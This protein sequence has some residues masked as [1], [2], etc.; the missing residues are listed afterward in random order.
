[1]VK[2]AVW[3]VSTGHTGPAAEAEPIA[4]GDSTAEAVPRYNHLNQLLPQ[5]QW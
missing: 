5:Y 2:A 1:M 3:F 4:L